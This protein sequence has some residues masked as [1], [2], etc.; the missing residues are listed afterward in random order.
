MNDI[1]AILQKVPQIEWNG[2]KLD[3]PELTVDEALDLTIEM[4]KY[5]DRKLEI[6]KT[7]LNKRLKKIFPN[8]S[9]EE[10]GKLPASL[11]GALT[12]KDE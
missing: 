12:P 4:E 11:L 8:A 9:D 1:K 10:L 6:S 3:A 7:M 2:I 5:P